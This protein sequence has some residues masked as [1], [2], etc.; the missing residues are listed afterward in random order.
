MSFGIFAFGDAI[1]I[2]GIGLHHFFLVKMDA[3][4]KSW[5]HQSLN[6]CFEKSTHRNY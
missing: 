1:K 5:L 4:R 3:S 6:H 2:E